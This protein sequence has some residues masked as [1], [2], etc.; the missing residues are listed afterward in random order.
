MLAGVL[1]ELRVTVGAAR[2]I[3]VVVMELRELA[4]LRRLATTVM[5]T[6]PVMSRTT[7]EQGRNL[8]RVR[9]LL[10]LDRPEA[11]STGTCPVAEPPGIRKELKI[12][13]L[14]EQ[15]SEKERIDRWQDITCRQQM[16][17]STSSFPSSITAS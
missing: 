2:P 17:C 16:S 7:V 8:E 9:V 11:R 12:V 3:H 13:E 6:L 14:S 10:H 5:I 15:S 1:A 4:E